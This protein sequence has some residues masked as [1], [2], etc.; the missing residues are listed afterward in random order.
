MNWGWSNLFSANISAGQSAAVRSENTAPLLLEP[1]LPI[2]SSTPSSFCAYN[3][4]KMLCCSRRPSRPKAE[5][6]RPPED[7]NITVDNILKKQLNQLIN[8]KDCPSFST[9]CAERNT[10]AQTSRIMNFANL[11]PIATVVNS[12]INEEINSSARRNAFIFNTIVTCTLNFRTAIGIFNLFYTINSTPAQSELKYYLLPL[13]SIVTFFIWLLNVPYFEK[14]GDVYRAAFGYGLPKDEEESTGRERILRLSVEAHPNSMFST[15]FK[16]GPVF[17][18]ANAS[19]FTQFLFALVSTWYLPADSILTS[20]AAALIGIVYVF[21]SLP[22]I[23]KAFDIIAG[24]I[25]RGLQLLQIYQTQRYVEFNS[26]RNRVTI[27]GNRDFSF[28]CMG[29]DVTVTVLDTCCAPSITT[30]FSL[31]NDQPNVIV[32]TN[33]EITLTHQK[34]GKRPEGYRS[35]D[36]LDI[37]IF[38]GADI[39]IRE[40]PNDAADTPTY[41]ISKSTTQVATFVARDTFFYVVCTAAS[42]FYSYPIGPIIANRFQS[43]NNLT[44]MAAFGVRNAIGHLFAMPQIGLLLYELERLL[45]EW[46]QNRLS[47][48]AQGCNKLTV[49]VS[50]L[51]IIGLSA[52]VLF[53]GLSGFMKDLNQSSSDTALA[54]I[55]STLSII[56]AIPRGRTLLEALERLNHIYSNTSEAYSQRILHIIREM[57]FPTPRSLLFQQRDTFNNLLAKWASVETNLNPDNPHDIMMSQAFANQV[58]TRLF[59]L[60]ISIALQQIQTAYPNPLNQQR[61]RLEINLYDH[62]GNYNDPLH[63]PSNALSSILMDKAVPLDVA[64]AVLRVMLGLITK[65]EANRVFTTYLNSLANAGVTVA[66]ET[67]A[68]PTHNSMPANTAAIQNSHTA[69]PTSSVDSLTN[70]TGRNVDDS[71]LVIPA[72]WAPMNVAAPPT[73]P[74]LQQR[75]S[76]PVKRD[77]NLYIGTRGGGVSMQSPR[78]NRSSS[79]T[80]AQPVAIHP[81]PALA[82]LWHNGADAGTGGTIDID[83]AMAM[84]REVDF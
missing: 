81:T 7:D 15:I 33:S 2:S 56:S 63:D 9:L 17:V 65:N 75:A 60:F 19:A 70:F 20:I 35:T 23:P 4:L 66:P 22:R 58:R 67:N 52:P 18:L 72:G 34:K 50:I 73:P 10:N 80:G 68:S 83:R 36:A 11:N 69:S 84:H 5:D 74:A 42:S 76:P 78:G 59:N 82:R 51:S 16:L 30:T 55:F 8:P 43:L 47:L 40:S 79:T 14:A 64:I 24:S 57:L 53:L 44:P 61:I 32:I 49:I 54:V 6:Y 26:E 27:Q 37:S 46:W 41:I 21:Q 25:G 48:G 31:A 45:N 3:F 39:R 62:I 77:G 29:N 71:F 1:P 13:I 28:F 12:I 38:C